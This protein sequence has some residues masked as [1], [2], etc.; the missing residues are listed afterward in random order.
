MSDYISKSSLVEQI[1]L[2]EKELSE[3]RELGVDSD[4]EM[5]LFAI[6][7]QETAIYRIKRC[8]QHELPTLDEKEIIRKAFERVVERLENIEP[9]PWE[10]VKIVKEECGINE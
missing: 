3:D 5:M 6:A 10:I 9:T 4:D 8:I 7:N 2:Y 1:K